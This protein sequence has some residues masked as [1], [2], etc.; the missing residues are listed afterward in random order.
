MDETI[1]PPPSFIKKVVKRE[2]EYFQSSIFVLFLNSRS[3][4]TNVDRE[5]S[6]PTRVAPGISTPSSTGYP[7]TLSSVYGPPDPSK[8]ECIHF[9]NNKAR[10]M[11]V[12]TNAEIRTPTDLSAISELKSTFTAYR[13]V[14]KRWKADVKLAVRRILRHQHST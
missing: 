5:D 3:E 14:I 2:R 7:L 6:I 11:S 13:E 8:Q 10:Q 1:P 9:R 12:R 4:E